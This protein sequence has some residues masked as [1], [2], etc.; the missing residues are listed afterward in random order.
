MSEQICCWETQSRHAVCT[1]IKSLRNPIPLFLQTI[2][3]KDTLFSRFSCSSTFL[4]VSPKYKVSFKKCHLCEYKTP[5]PLSHP[6]SSPSKNHELLKSHY[7]EIFILLISLSITEKTSTSRTAGALSRP[8]R[9]V[10]WKENKQ[11]AVP[12]N[13]VKQ[14]NTYSNT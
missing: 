3:H 2:F 4:N 11:P 12:I 10:P 13:T 14:Y 6:T 7:S 5:Q 8:E 9:K 1:S